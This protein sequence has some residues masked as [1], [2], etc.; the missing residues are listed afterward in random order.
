MRRKVLDFAAKIVSTGR[1]IIL[2]VTQAIWEDLR[3]EKL[4]ERSQ[5]PIPI[6]G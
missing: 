2:K 6:F 5:N 3:F 4:W 1:E